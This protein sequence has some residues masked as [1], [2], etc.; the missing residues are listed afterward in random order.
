ML[1]DDNMNDLKT[2][3]GLVQ[4]L[5]EQDPKCRNCDGYLYMRVLFAFASKN[6]VNIGAMTVPDFLMF[7]HGNDFPIFESVRRS[8][9]KLQQHRPDLAASEAVEGFRA[10]NEAKFYSYAVGDI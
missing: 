2:I 4:A 9:Q 5:L 6:G 10:E 1:G 3:Q 8:R 7:H